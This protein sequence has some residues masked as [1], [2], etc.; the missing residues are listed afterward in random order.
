AGAGHLV[1]A[2][3]RGPE[4]PGADELVAELT[5]LGTRVTVVACDVADREA[6]ARMLDGI[7]AEHP[8]TA[9]IHAAAVLDDGVV[10]SL[11]PGQMDAVLR[12]KAHGALHLHELTRDLDLSAFVLCSSFGATFGLPAL[13]N[14][15]PGNAF[16]DALAEAR[17][18]EGLPATSVAWGTWAGT[19]MAAGAVGAR[20]RLEGIHEM[21]PELAVTALRHVLDDGVVDSLTPGQ[22]DAVLRIKA[23]GALH[24][25]E[26][27]RDLDL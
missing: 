20:G 23:H 19:G 21:A 7:P 18:A 10:D 3:R 17:R 12:I 4:A 24:L 2:G 8:L 15:A 5:A 27:T 11:T 25:H 9:V 1:L 26:L 14:Y 22:M 16:L 6:V 13:G